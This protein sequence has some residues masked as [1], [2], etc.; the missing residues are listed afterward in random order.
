MRR[1]ALAA[2]L[3]SLGIVAL[4]LIAYNAL[5]IPVYSAEALAE[6][7]L[8]YEAIGWAKYVAAAILLVIADRAVLWREHLGWRRALLLWTP[9]A[10]FVA[11][12]YL[13]WV[14]LA[15]A[16]LAYLERHGRSD[17]AFSGA[18]FYMLIVFPV[19]FGIT[20]VNAAVVRRRELRLTTR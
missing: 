17:G 3:L 16:R 5:A 13:Q 9:L 1:F 2:I 8:F 14:V 7:E 4:V 12:A 18:L 11:Y 19:A 15:D 6:F 20:A 10:L